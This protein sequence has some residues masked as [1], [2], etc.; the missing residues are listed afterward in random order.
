MR[1]RKGT[2]KGEIWFSTTVRGTTV[3]LYSIKAMGPVG[4]LLNA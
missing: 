3:P 1:N 2:S 4:V